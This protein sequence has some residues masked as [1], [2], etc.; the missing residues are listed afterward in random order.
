M[1]E[2]VTTYSSLLFL[3][4]LFF[5]SSTFCTTHLISVQNF[6]FSP[7]SV[8][9]I[10]GD[11]ITWQWVDGSHTTTCDGVF[12]GTSL[13]PGA[14]TWDS[15]IN[16]TTT[17][18]SYVIEVDGDYNYVCMPHSPNMAGMILATPLPV[19]LVSFAATAGSGF[20][21]LSW[22]TATEKNNS[23]FEIQRKTGADWERVSFIQGYGTTTKENSYSFRDNISAL[24]SGVIYYRLKQIDYNGTYEYS[25]EIMVNSTA[26][27]DFSLMQNYPNPFNPGT[28]IN[29]SIP[30][31]SNVILKVYD[32][33]G[34]E[35][36][37]LVNEN[38]ISGNYTVNFNAYRLA[39][40]IYYY[41]ITAGSF[42]KT[43]KMILM[44]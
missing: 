30:Q 33:N 16:S 22:K 35:V 34:S 6:S 8:N 3:G 4:L 42:S 26:P 25:K 39:S 10:V 12:P 27:S 19:E 29:Y 28:L 24:L 36:A 9:A 2:K 13:P 37:T 20:A 38:K 14:P 5:S 31:N 18:F 11:T 1:T 40:G 43:R 32:S 44:K 41:T 21:Y 23:G 7:A 15:P 17:F